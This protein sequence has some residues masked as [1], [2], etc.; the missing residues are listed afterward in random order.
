MAEVHFTAT[1]DGEPYIARR[2]LAMA[3]AEFPWR[4]IGLVSDKPFSCG[5]F[6]SGEATQT[7]VTTK[8]VFVEGAATSTKKLAGANVDL[9][10]MMM[11]DP[12]VGSDEVTALALDEKGLEVPLRRDRVTVTPSGSLAFDV[13]G[14]RFTATGELP[15][16]FCGRL[17]DRP[18]IEWVGPVVDFV[19]AEPAR[20]GLAGKSFPVRFAVPD[21]WAYASV[22]APWSDNTWTAPDGV[23]SLAVRLETPRAAF[24]EDVARSAA[25]RSETSAASGY[26]PLRNE[27]VGTGSW[28]LDLGDGRTRSLSVRRYEPGWPY[29]VHCA[30]DADAPGAEAVFDE[31][32]AACSTL[33]PK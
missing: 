2:A 23:V 10:L 28:I 9:R 14:P 29:V 13:T 25:E 32:I 15:I 30:V 18:S 21:G 16:K 4:W 20:D 33:T 24:L 19:L 12:T 22:D 8:T 17:V 6:V 31:A 27:A 5:D 3:D 1:L 11:F 7:T 26:L